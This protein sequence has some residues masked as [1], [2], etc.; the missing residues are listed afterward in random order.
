MLFPPAYTMSVPKVQ[1]LNVSAGRYIQYVPQMQKASLT[2]L[3]FA[4]KGGKHHGKQ[5]Y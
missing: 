4:F 3:M 5:K 1:S 2:G